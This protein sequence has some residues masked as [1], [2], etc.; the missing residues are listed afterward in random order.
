MRARTRLA[1]ALATW[2]GA[3]LM[4]PAP[5]TWGSVAAV[6]LHWI[7]CGF[8]P[9]VHVASTLLVT[10]LGVWA[11]QEVA[12]HRGTKD[13]Q[14]VVIDEVV[15]TL[16]AMGAVRT[17]PLWLQALALVLF[18]LFDI[19]KPGPIRKA[20]NVSPPGVGIMFDD[21]LAGG[22]AALVVIGVRLAL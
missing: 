8:S 14:I 22:L 6:P 3:G 7:L 15:G 12:N 18:R 17:G 11:G 10:V 1:Y 16:I 13:P 5:G 19:T 9:T 20:E 21:V 4:K 2:A